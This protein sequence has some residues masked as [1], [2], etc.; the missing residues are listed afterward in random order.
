MTSVQRRLERVPAGPRTSYRVTLAVLTL[1]AT[2]YALLQSLV[3]PTLPELQR[4]L[5]VSE[6]T[7]SWI[8]TAYLLSA[9]VATPIIGR[10]GDMYGKE[11]V[12]VSVL[13]MLAVGTLISALAS[14]IGPMLLGRIIQGIGGGIFPLG[15]GIIR[16]EFPPR[17][18]AGGIGLMS[19]LIGVGGGAGVVLAGVIV[20]HLSYHWLFWVPLMFIVP[21]AIAAHVF[22]PESPVKVSG[23]VN[24]PAAVLMSAGLTALLVGVT[25]TAQ[26]GW[27]SPKTLTTIALGFGLLAWW[28]ALDARARTPLV[29]MRMMRLRG[30][31]TTTSSR[32]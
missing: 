1:A 18:V 21:A 17:E 19:S 27:T 25:E 13:A 10:L 3:L 22:V 5:H 30:V 12:L 2:S 14:S 26:W 29:D 4:S 23:R 24:W 20:E 6:A 7:V 11:R 8:L 31:W 28:I 9:S 16:D 15:F 32:S